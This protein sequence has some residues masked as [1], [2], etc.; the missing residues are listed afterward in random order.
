MNLTNNTGRRGLS[1]LEIENIKQTYK[2]LQSISKTAE[3]T[4]YNPDTVNK[5]VKNTSRL[6]KHSRFSE[7]PVIRIDIDE[8]IEQYNSISE[9]SKKT[10]ISQSSICHC[11]CG[12]TKRAG[13][14]K[15]FYKK[16][17]T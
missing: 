14:Y 16:N 11:L 10:G 8:N 17:K 2:K 15:W 12:K 13:T 6:D 1:E 7:R 4:G 5:Y 9:A 3:E